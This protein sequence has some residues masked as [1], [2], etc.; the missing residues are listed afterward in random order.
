MPRYYYHCDNCG[1]EFE[2]R[3][4]MSE[5]QEECIKCSVVGSLVRIPQLIQKQEKR[6]DNSTSS[7]R[8]IDAIEENRQL[9]KQMKKEGRL[10]D[11]N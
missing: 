3:H 2:I 9:L 1:G 10:D 5:T 6:V 7:S 4:G 11:Y 8:V